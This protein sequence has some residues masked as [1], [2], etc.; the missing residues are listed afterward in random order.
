MKKLRFEAKTIQDGASPLMQGKGIGDVSIVTVDDN[1]VLFEERGEWQG[2]SQATKFSNVFKWTLDKLSGLI[3][4]EHLRYGKDNPVLLFH[5]KPV[6]SF[7]LRSIDAQFCESQTRFGYAEFSQNAIR[8][9]W[10]VVGYER[11]EEVQYS[12]QA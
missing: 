2:F 9:E 10:R 12:Y 8:L 1:V 11:D 7:Y 4:L 3:T 6:S 5:L